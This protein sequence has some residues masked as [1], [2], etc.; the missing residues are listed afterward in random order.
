MS[1]DVTNYF[2]GYPVS[3]MIKWLLIIV[4]VLMIAFIV[5]LISLSLSSRKQPELGLQNN[6][7]LACG[8]EKNCVCSEFPSAGA[9]I[10][11]FSYSIGDTQAWEKL[12]IV[13]ANSGGNIITEDAGYMRVVYE[14]RLFRFMDDVEFRQDNGKQR[15]QV[16]SASRVGRSDHGANRERVEA[17]RRAFN[18]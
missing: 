9:F 6:L 11:P 13:I 18:Q 1:Y 16:R 2:S 10:Q 7:L 15:I 8:S 17:L 5:L 4:A 14:T 3:P 12:K